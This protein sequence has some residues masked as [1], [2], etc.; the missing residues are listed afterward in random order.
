M[1]P[2][3]P[4]ERPNGRRRQRVTPQACLRHDVAKRPEVAPGD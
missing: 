2:A 4:V 1:R 3:Q